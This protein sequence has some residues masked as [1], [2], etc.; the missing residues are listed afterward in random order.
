MINGTETG[1]PRSVY[2]KVGID[3]HGVL[4]THPFFKEMGKLFVAAG[5]EVHIIT[6]RQFNERVQAK[7]EKLGIKKGV[8]YTHYF[9]ITDYLIKKGHGVRWDDLDN[10]WFDKMAWDAAK[11]EYC[12]EQKI[13]IHFDD[14]EEYGN[15]FTTPFYLKKCQVK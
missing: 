14:S 5:H 10:P 4:D 13:D 3:I 7:F 12:R 9:S 6:G 8:N 1:N 11:S 15:Y 2:Q